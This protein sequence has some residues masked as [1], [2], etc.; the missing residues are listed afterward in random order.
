MIFARA[1]FFFILILCLASPRK[2]QRESPNLNY[3]GRRQHIT[4]KVTFFSLNC[5]KRRSEKGKTGKKKEKTHP[6]ASLLTV[7]FVYSL[8]VHFLDEGCEGVD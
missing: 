4:L 8:S 2:Q 3:R 5:K 6:F 7:T 1:A